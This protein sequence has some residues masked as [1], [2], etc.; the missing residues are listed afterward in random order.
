M[1]T[2]RLIVA[3]AT[4]VWS[5]LVSAHCDTLDGPVVAAARVALDSG[6]ASAVLV[7]VQE[8]DDAE[9]R[10]ALDRAR[11]VRKAGGDA[12]ELADRYFF[13]TLVRVHRAGEGAPYTGLK[14]AGVIEP[15]VAAADGA[16]RSGN[17]QPL[18]NL[19]RQRTENGLHEHFE[20]VLAKAKYAPK[21]IKAGRAYASAYV[22]FVHY[23]ERLFNA[24]EDLAP[25]HLAAPNREH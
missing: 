20:Q 9:I 1:T 18:A 16:L 14:P 6:D 10:A 15:P 7:W 2:H 19:I 12:K 11:K 5:A 13:E 22:E 8:R 24:A 3:A 17:L 4:L 23:A 21:D 25:E